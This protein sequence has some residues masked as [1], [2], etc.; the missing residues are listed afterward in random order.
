MVPIKFKES[1]KTFI[2]PASMTD[3]ECGSLPVH[4][5][6]HHIISCWKLS[7]KERIRML[8]TGKVW[9]WVWGKKQQPIS[10]GCENP[11]ND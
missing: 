6:E 3:K 7:F 5:N 1:N 8:F 11:F 4:Q 9:L 2:K 10:L